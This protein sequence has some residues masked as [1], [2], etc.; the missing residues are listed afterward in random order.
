MYTKEEY[1]QYAS[2]LRESGITE[3]GQIQLILNFVYRLSVIATDVYIENLNQTK[4][5]A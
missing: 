5:G 4:N 2:M 3:D 1:D